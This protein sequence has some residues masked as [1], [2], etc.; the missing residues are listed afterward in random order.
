MLVTFQGKPG[1]F[2]HAMYLDSEAGIASG[3]ELL[4]FPKVLA[5]PKLEIRNDALVGTL[6]LSTGRARRDF[7]HGVQV[8]AAGSRRPSRDRSQ[9]PGYLL[10]VLPHV[11]GSARICELGAGI[12]AYRRHGKGSLD[13]ARLP[14]AASPLLRAGGKAAGAGGS[15]RRST[16]WPIFPSP[17]AEVVHDYLGRL[18]RN[19]MTRIFSEGAHDC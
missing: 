16:S 5:Q 8:R 19:L 10:K 13:G 9:A 2:T 6:G 12:Y 14:R 11:D 17:A 15:C 4:G 1:G 7:D 3:R 18:E